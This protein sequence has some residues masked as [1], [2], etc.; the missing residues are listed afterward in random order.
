M[1]KCDDLLHMKEIPTSSNPVRLN[2]V[3]RIEFI[4]VT[5]F[6]PGSEVSAIQDITFLISEG[7]KIALVGMSGSGK[8][9]IAFLL[10]RMLD[11][12]SGVI[13]INGRKIEDYTL[14]SLREKFVF[15]LQETGVLN[16]SIKDNLRLGNPEATDKQLLQAVN[17]VAF[18]RDL[19]QRA[20]DLSGGQRQR[21]AIARAL[22][23]E[24]AEVF[25]FDEFT[26]AVDPINEEEILVNIDS[27]L[28]G[29]TQI[30]IAHRYSTIRGTDQIFVMSDG[31]MVQK[32]TQE[33]LLADPDGL[34]Y[35]LWI[36]QMKK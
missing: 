17:C 22:L 12:H 33:V 26:S 3:W 24:K 2:E 32:G 6:Y 28:E 36:K 15:C 5:A 7:E 19:N 4:G 18:D 16:R 29:K 11:P 20:S 25:I 34:F 9:T 13:L 14:E 30:I 10:T 31:K 23:Q 21:L 27:K 1:D 35:K 8:S